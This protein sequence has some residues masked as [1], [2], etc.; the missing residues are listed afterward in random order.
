MLNFTMKAGWYNILWKC[1]DICF[2]GNFRKLPAILC[3]IKLIV[4]TSYKV[5][6]IRNRD[7]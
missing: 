3:N 1:P 4:Y 2:D 7:T 5:G 6:T